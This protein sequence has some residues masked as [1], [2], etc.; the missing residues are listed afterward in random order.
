MK[1]TLSILLFLSLAACAGLR[2]GGLIPG[3]STLE[4]VL[5]AMGPPALQWQEPDGSRRLAYPRGPMGV[6]TY[7]VD[8]APNGRLA[9]IENAM[10]MSTF[11]RVA[12]GLNADEVSRLLGPPVDEWTSYFTARDELVLGWR[13]CDDWNQ[14]ARFFVLFDGKNTVRS[15]M[16]LLENQVGS[17]GGSWGGCWCSR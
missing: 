7:M 14:L 4:D 11:A 16:S 17:C 6:H 2:A 5:V 3:Q 15:T 8:V 12:A 1:R 10:D 13:Y 9:R